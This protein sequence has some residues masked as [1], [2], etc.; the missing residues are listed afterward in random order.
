MIDRKYQ[1]KGYG[2]KALDLL[3]KYV[4][5]RP[6]ADYLYASYEEGENGPERFYHKY[7]F[8]KTGEIL[9]DEIVIRLK[10]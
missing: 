6:N 2:K 9:E 4:R 3:C 1:K 8:E 5:K 10:L 7:G